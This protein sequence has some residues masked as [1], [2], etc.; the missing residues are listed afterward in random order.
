MRYVASI[1]FAI[2]KRRFGTNS[3]FTDVTLDVSNVN[4]PYY[5]GIWGTGKWECTDIWLT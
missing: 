3:N 4:G 2:T 5:L 1:S